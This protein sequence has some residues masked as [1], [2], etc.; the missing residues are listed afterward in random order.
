MQRSK[1]MMAL[2]LGAGLLMGSKGRAETGPS[3][4]TSS[5]A[6]EAWLRYRDELRR[7]HEAL[8]SLEEAKDPQLRAQGLY[9]LQTLEA[10]AHNMYIAP[11]TQYPAFYREA[12]FMPMAEVNWGDPNPDFHYHWAWIDGAHSYRVFGNKRGSDWATMQVYKGFWGDEVQGNLAT[13]DFDDIPADADGNFEIFLGPNPPAESDGRYWVKLDPNLHNIAL[14]IREV[15]NDW[16]KDVP[17][18]V[19]IEILDRTPNAPIHFDEA[20]LAARIDR[21]R[22]FLSFNYDFTIARFKDSPKNGDAASPTARNR[23]KA[24]ENAVQ[25]GGNPLACYSGSVY[26]I[27]PDEALIIEVEPAKARYWG[28]QLES[29]WRQTIDY[30]YHNSSINGRQ[31]RLDRDGKFR[32]V[33]ALSDPGVPNWLD[34]AGLQVGGVILRWFLS[35]GCPVPATHKV[36]LADLRRHL[37]ADT[38][39]VSAEERRLLLQ[40]RTEAARRRWRQ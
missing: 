16:E 21:A 6:Q 26:D 13:V 4:A 24:S 15:F 22:K 14:N 34:P 10:T 3:A 39:S 40:R 1:L 27:A 31:A 5:P 30:S 11:R 19:R 20:E 23:F 35:D 7:E 8:L 28:I 9:Y 18:D 25:Q 38:P 32:A 2:A 29:I 37:P 36:K 12:I 17:I 33:L